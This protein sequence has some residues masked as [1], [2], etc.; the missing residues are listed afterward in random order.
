MSPHPSSTRRPAKSAMDPTSLNWHI[1]IRTLEKG[2]L[3][4]VWEPQGIML[5]PRNS[6][7]AATLR[8]EW[9]RAGGLS[10]IQKESV[11]ERPASQRSCELQSRFTSSRQPSKEGT[12]EE[13]TL[14][15]FSSS[16]CSPSTTPYW[17]NS[18]ETRWQGNLPVENRDWQ[19]FSVRA[20]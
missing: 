3:T 17:S 7:A 15:W 1:H 10:G 16:L 18:S 2:L 8:P 19:T 20:R 5:Y 13:N 6:R 14:T 9:K 11:M 4:K 12:R